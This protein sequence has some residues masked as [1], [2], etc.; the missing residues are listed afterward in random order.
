M[1]QLP[2]FYVVKDEARVD[3]KDT[4][5]IPRVS[6]LKVN[7]YNSG[8]YKAVVR[9]EGRDD[10]TLELPQINADYYLANNIPIIR[11]AQSTIPVMA[12][13]DQF[14]FEL[15]ADSPFQTA[16]TSIDW[17]GT[18]DNKGIR[19]RL[20]DLNPSCKPLRRNLGGSTLTR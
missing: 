1:A 13:G 10:F 16:F 8:P 11:N 9:S 2:A 20:N 19:V 4:V 15:I 6:R 7:S 14:E 17:E 3:I 12:K 18:Y 5:N